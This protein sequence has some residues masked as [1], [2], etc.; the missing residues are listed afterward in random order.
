MARHPSALKNR[1]MIERQ[2]PTLQRHDDGARQL[3]PESRA[4]LETLHSEGARYDT[5]IMRL[6]ALLLSEAR[7]QVRRRT[8]GLAHPSGRDLDDLAMQAADDA[9][10]AILGKLD[11]FRGDAL[12]TTWARRFVELEV[13]GKIRRRLG[14][15]RETPTET[16]TLELRPGS[17]EDP[18][19]LCEAAD[20]ADRLGE[21]MVDELTGHQREVLV[22]LTMDGVDAKD[23][24]ARIDST[25]GALYKTL[26][27]ARRKLKHELAG[28]EPN[29]RRGACCP[30][31]AADRAEA[32]RLAQRMLVCAEV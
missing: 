32:R 31:S 16:E 24:A 30:R 3:D 11:R 15:A 12:F 1:C 5:A 9:L 23:L 6:H 20:L 19:S 22:A 21:L 27:D 8:A 14:H 26:H 2:T 10:I 17:D 7:Y 4:W 18:Q 25:P 28:G 13:P 29:R